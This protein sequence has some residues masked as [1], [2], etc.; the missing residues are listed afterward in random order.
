MAAGLLD[1]DGSD[2]EV[3]GFLSI[4]YLTYDSCGGRGDDGLQVEAALGYLELMPSSIDP[5]ASLVKQGMMGFLPIVTSL[6]SMGMFF[7]SVDA[8]LVYVVDGR[9]ADD[10]RIDRDVLK[11]VDRGRTGSLLLMTEWT[12]EL[13][14][15]KLS[16]FAAPFILMTIFAALVVCHRGDDLVS[17]RAAG[18][19][20][21]AADVR[22][23]GVCDGVAGDLG[24]VGGVGYGQGFSGVNLGVPIGGVEL[25]VL[26]GHL[27][28]RDGGADESSCNDLGCTG[29]DDLPIDRHVAAVKGVD[30]LIDGDHLQAPAALDV[31]EGGASV[32]TVVGVDGM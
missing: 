26:D 8:A 11:S 30:K 29:D 27:D 14:T 6:G 20:V 5:A 10:L 4:L 1:Y 3:D 17:R 31:G 12:I 18:L 32:L 21:D 7:L 19:L 16:C 23:S 22:P 28:R 24:Y 13:A 25:G 9:L 2:V 15:L